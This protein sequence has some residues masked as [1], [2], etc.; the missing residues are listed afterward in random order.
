MN[1]Q[2]LFID[3]QKLLHKTASYYHHRYGVEYEEVLS[4]A[5]LIFAETINKYESGHGCMFSSYLY[6]R[7]SQLHTFCRTEQKYNESVPHLIAE[8]EDEV[9]MLPDNS[10]YACFVQAIEWRESLSQ[11]SAEAREVY[12]RALAGD[13]STKTPDR[14]SASKMRRTLREEGWKKWQ[15]AKILKELK[16]LHENIN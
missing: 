15:Y 6:S 9:S 1:S 12:D 10:P 7:L 11:L 2:Q 8:D 14:V 5:F 4:E 13:F 3:N 16:Q